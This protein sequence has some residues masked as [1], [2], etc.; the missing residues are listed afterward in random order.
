MRGHD[1]AVNSVAFAPDGRTLASGSS[2]RTVKLWDPATG[3][4]QM[5]LWER[6]P[7]LAVAFAPDGTALASG[8]A[9]SKPVRPENSD[10]GTVKLWETGTG[11]ERAI[12]QVPLIRYAFRSVCSV[13]FA[14]GG[15]VLAAGV[16]GLTADTPFLGTV[17]LWDTGVDKELRTFQIS[18]ASPSAAFLSEGKT[19]AVTDGAKVTFYEAATGKKQAF[20]QRRDHGAVT[21]LALSPDGKI[22]AAGEG[23]SEAGKY[24]GSYVTL[25]DVATGK[26]LATFQGHADHIESLAFAPD[27]KVLATGSQDATIKLWEVPTGKALA[28]LAGHAGPVLSVAFAPD[29]KTLASGSKDGT[30]KLW[31]MAKALKQKAVK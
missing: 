7:V 6:G 5:T 14:P 9:A 11:T 26:E 21:T 18:T 28:T 13:T 16:S 23:K 12:F 31:D 24:L 4:E 3:R 25:W 10:A 15:K 17:I 30:V 22:L 27:G 20:F 2:D 1:A 19:L 8:T 29:G